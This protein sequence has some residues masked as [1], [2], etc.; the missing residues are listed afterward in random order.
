MR[1]RRISFDSILT[2]QISRDS[3]LEHCVEI[4]MCFPTRAIEVYTHTSLHLRAH[5]VNTMKKWDMLN[6]ECCCA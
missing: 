5:P 6:G 2:L 3:I 4:L 1:E